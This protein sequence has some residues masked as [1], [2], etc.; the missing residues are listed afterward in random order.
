MFFLLPA[1]LSRRATEGNIVFRPS[2]LGG[3]GEN[4][5]EGEVEE[6]PSKPIQ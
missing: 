3:G 4:V 5:E 1:V 6:E 2:Q